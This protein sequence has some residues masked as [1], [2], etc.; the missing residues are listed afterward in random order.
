MS[1][2]RTEL[3]FQASN[4]SNGVCLTQYYS[5]L[6]GVCGVSVHPYRPLSCPQDEA[7]EHLLVNWELPPPRGAQAAPPPASRQLP[8]SPAEGSARAEDGPPDLSDTLIGVPASPVATAAGVPAPRTLKRLR[9]PGEPLPSDKLDAAP[10][11]QILLPPAPAHLP[12]AAGSVRPIELDD[13]DDNDEPQQ[14]QQPRASAKGGGGGNPF[15]SSSR[16]ARQKV[17][18]KRT[19]WTLREHASRQY[20]STCKDLGI[21]HFPKSIASPAHC[22]LL[23]VRALWRAIRM[24]EGLGLWRSRLFRSCIGR[25]WLQHCSSGGKLKRTLRP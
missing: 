24:N 19:F 7:D 4:T 16:M 20:V 23:P 6:A 11:R 18:W 1:P 5:G 10:R 8:R 12:S 9:R 13:D 3:P 25:E 15:V 2:A 21:C 22:T 14:Q 17:R